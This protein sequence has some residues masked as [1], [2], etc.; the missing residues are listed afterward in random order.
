MVHFMSRGPHTLNKVLFYYM[1]VY[2]SKNGRM[3]SQKYIVLHTPF[4]S[5]SGTHV[6]ETKKSSVLKVKGRETVDSIGE[7]GGFEL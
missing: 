2:I 6:K 5:P 1:I 4:S 3:P 7:Q